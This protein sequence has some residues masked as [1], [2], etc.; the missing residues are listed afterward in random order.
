MDNNRVDMY[1]NAHKALR[2]MLST[3]AVQAGATD[4]NDSA[5]VEQLMATWRT[6]LLGLKRHHEGE[7]QVIHPFLARGAP[8][9]DKPFKA[10]HVA[11]QVFLD[12]LQLHVQRLV[13]GQVP[14]EMRNPIGLAFYRSWNVF[15]SGYL[16]HMQREETEAQGLLDRTCLPQ[17]L[18]DAL[19]ANQPA[20]SPEDVTT[21]I[22][23]LFPALPLYEDA[24]MLAGMRSFIPPD[25][26]NNLAGRIRQVMGD[27]AWNKIQAMF[28]AQTSAPATPPSE[29]V[30]AGG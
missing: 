17:E 29:T 16:M 10:D 14:A 28:G 5:N 24:A 25:A 21:M 27:T 19:R 11:Q 6:V 3:F 15:Y 7:E 26:F 22:Q 2:N 23:F 9:G 4:W 12:D 8:G 30:N 1:T 20:M 13:S 18:T